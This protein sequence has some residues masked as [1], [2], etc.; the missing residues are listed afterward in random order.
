MAN[1]M[2]TEINTGRAVAAVEHLIGGMS[3]TEQENFL[4]QLAGLAAS[5]A[6]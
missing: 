1:R 6:V 5:R 2:V 3:E 4:D